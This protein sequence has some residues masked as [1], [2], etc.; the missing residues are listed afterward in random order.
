MVCVI[1]TLFTDTMAIFIFLAAVV[2]LL[3]SNFT[4]LWSENMLHMNP[5][6]LLFIE[7]PFVGNIRIA[8]IFS[9]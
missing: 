3:I 8:G 4:A 1:Q 2:L 7:I 5:I 6:F 9:S